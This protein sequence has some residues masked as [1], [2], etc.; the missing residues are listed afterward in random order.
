MSFQLMAHNSL[1][2]ST[3]EQAN[4]QL[5]QHEML[6]KEIHAYQGTIDDAKSKGNQVTMS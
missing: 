5:N 6:L 2:I 3:K 1:Y 4:E